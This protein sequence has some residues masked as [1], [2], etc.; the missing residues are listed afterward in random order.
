VIGRPSMKERTFGILVAVL[1]ISG[2]PILLLGIVLGAIPLFLLGFASSPIGIT[3]LT[4]RSKIPWFQAKRMWLYFAFGIIAVGYLAFLY[5][6][7]LGDFNL[8]GYSLIAFMGGN[9]LLIELSRRARK[10]PSSA[11]EI[12]FD[13]W[14][15]RKFTF[16]NYRLTDDGIVRTRVGTFVNPLA[17]GVTAILV[18]GLIGFG[19][20]P[21]NLAGLTFIIFPLAVGTILA[22]YLLSLGRRRRKFAHLSPEE[23]KGLKESIL[24]PWSNVG[25]AELHGLVFSIVYDGEKHRI[26]VGGPSF[27][28]VKDSLKSKLGERFIVR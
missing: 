6:E 2:T 13:S 19:L 1:V 28:I 7:K 12:S 11:G 24:I 21:V 18:G 16:S 15:T 3:I 20:L 26:H 17:I 4:L 25:S 22:A 27:E 23:L 9:T 5:G 10:H 8:Q 14:E